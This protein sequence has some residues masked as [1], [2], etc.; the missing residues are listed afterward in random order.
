M[1]K[2]F[3][4][5]NLATILAQ[6]DKRVL[7]IDADLRRGYLHKYFNYD[8]QP[9]LAEYF[10][11]QHELGSIVRSTEVENLSIISRGKSPANPSEVIKLRK[12]LQTCSR[13]CLVS[14]TIFCIDTPPVLS[15]D[16]WASLFHNTRVLIW[17]L[18]VMRKRR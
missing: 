3:I 15:R 4:S 18:H 5:T 2:S 7:I 8:V 10:N 12:N 16:R 13:T 17:W 11:G 9:G 14:L 1:G 6:S